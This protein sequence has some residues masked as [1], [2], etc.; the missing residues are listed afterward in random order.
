MG[1]HPNG[2]QAISIPC[3]DC[4][5][6]RLTTYRDFTPEELDVV[7]DLKRGEWAVEKGAAII[8]EN[9]AGRHLYTVLRGWGFRYKTLPD[10]RRQ[11]LGYILPGDFVGLQTSVFGL[12]EHGVEALTE[13][14]LCVFPRD[15][16]A[17]L[18]RGCPSLA[19]DLTWLAARQERFLDDH[20]VTVGRRHALE[21]IAFILVHFYRRA[22]EAGLVRGRRFPLPV[23]QQHLADTLGLSLV[24]TNRTLKRLRATGT[25]GWRDGTLEIHDEARLIDIAGAA[26]PTDRHR[27]FI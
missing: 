5:L 13:M 26:S 15:K 8:L 21:R 3:T 10:G 19:Y 14:L 7:L 23:T 25:I 2:S 18:Y 9:D 22:I 6:R 20:V 11:I 24:H 16:L 27:P 17:D 12:M 4:P 1:I